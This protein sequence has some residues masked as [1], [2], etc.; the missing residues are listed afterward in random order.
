MIQP[1]FVESLKE[2]TIE[3]DKLGASEQKTMTCAQCHVEYYFVPQTNRIVHPLGW[4]STAEEM[5]EYYATRPNGFAADFVH[6]ESGA[7]MLKAQHPDYEEF[8]GGIHAHAGLSCSDCHMPEGSHHIASPL[9]TVEKTCLKCHEGRTADWMI[10][11]VRYNQDAVA[12]LQTQCGQ[13]LARTHRLVGEKA[14]TL[15]PE[16]LAEAREGL[17]E[18][19][20]YWDYVAAANSMGAH[21]PV[22]ALGNLAKAG[23]IAARVREM[24]LGAAK[25][26][27]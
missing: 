16:I 8:L 9:L 12:A 25:S 7:P 24:V 5:Y 18:A 11:R 17:R 21:N 13:D 15:P 20:W 3:F 19:Q 6:P 26:P 22:G 23:G 14:K 4:G 1:G 27:R 2:R 10:S